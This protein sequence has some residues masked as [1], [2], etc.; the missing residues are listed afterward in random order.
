MEIRERKADRL[1]EIQFTIPEPEG[2]IFQCCLGCDQ[3]EGGRE[4]V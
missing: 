4:A 1:M 2:G 3:L